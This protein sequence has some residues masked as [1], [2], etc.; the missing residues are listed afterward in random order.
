[1][2][3]ARGLGPAAYSV[4]GIVYSTLLASE[5]ILRF[6]VPQS[7][8][9]LVGGASGSTA[10]LEAS[11]MTIV[12]LV[13]LVGFTAIFVMAPQLAS[14]L[15]VPNGVSLF[16]IA[17]LDLP[18]FGLYTC[19]AHILN[20]R[21]DFFVSA[22]GTMIYGMAKVA[23]TAVLLA[24]PGLTVEGAL[25]V[26]VAASVLGLAVL[27][28]RGGTRVLRPTLTKRTVILALAWPVLLGDIGVQTLLGLDLWSLN[29]LGGAIP[30]EV[31]G[32]Y[33]AALNLAR[34]PNML[35][36]VLASILMPSIARA[37]ADGDKKTALRL[38]LG[39]TRFLAVM[40]LPACALIAGSADEILA[41]LFSD[42]YAGGGRF[43]AVLIFAQGLGFTCLGALQSILVGAGAAPAGAR[44]IYAGVAVAIVLNFVLVPIFGAIGAAAA[45]VLA[46]LTAACLVGSEVRRRLGGVVEPKILMW[47]IAVSA[48]V[49][50]LGW[51]VPASGLL[52]LVK[53]VVLGLLYL[54][55]AWA[56]GLASK[57]DLTLLRG[58][59]KA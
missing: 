7:L 34:V 11:G 53:L 9:K 29:A 25:I 23:G 27:L 6:G 33:V 51:L 26:N 20:G 36:F 45:A 12:L 14:L 22:I 57:A 21:R 24:G 30:A 46:L 31:K 44:R 38:V 47:A 32:Q 43:L 42:A 56:V 40:V 10:L 35:A 41:L 55:V 37:L 8:T 4:Y 39:A 54:A 48:F 15:H 50:G 2:M 52:V 28:V 1:M 3:L 5:L 58:G 59:T 17:A 49:G 16:R 13:N 18:F 19:L